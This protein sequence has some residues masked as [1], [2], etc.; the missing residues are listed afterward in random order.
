MR[1]ATLHRMTLKA[2]TIGAVFFVAL[3]AG[4]TP[5]ATAQQQASNCTCAK[6][7]DASTY[8][9]ADVI[10]SGQLAKANVPQAAP[11]GFE[12]AI[13]QFKV[14]RVFKGTVTAAATVYSLAAADSCG[15]TGMTLGGDYVIFATVIEHDN[16]YRPHG[17]PDGGL[18]AG[19]CSGSLTLGTLTGPP[20]YLGTGLRPIGAGAGAASAR[21]KAQERAA[22]ILP[23]DDNK[24]IQPVVIAS[25][26]L[27][28]VGLA[29]RLIAGKRRTVL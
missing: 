6:A 7:P 2:I 20:T 5:S 26:A 3:A 15:F 9:V 1:V 25:L 10:F 24:W 29:A 14:D 23:R 17:T 22:E 4:V 8:S 21:A 13:Y 19:A 11:T 18:Y 27:A 16:P 28:V 12:A